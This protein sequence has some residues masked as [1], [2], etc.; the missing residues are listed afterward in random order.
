[1]GE[2]E[3]QAQVAGGLDLSRVFVDA[4]GCPVKE[5]IYRVARRHGLEVVLVSNS[6]MRVPQESW[7]E[8]IVVGGDLDAADDWI[9]ENVT[10]TDVVVS[11]DI[12]LASRCLEKGTRVIGHRGRAFTV[13]NIGDALANRE[14][15]S[16]LREVGNVTGGPAAFGKRD[17][18]RFLEGFEEILRSIH[19]G[20]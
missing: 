18:S 10:E 11:A 14:L 20:R 16:Q 12:P 2:G 19:R 5:E 1:M 8:L 9:V 7:I 15:L 17:R 4:D 13:D 3:G 6:W